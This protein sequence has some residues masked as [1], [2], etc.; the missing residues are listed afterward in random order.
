MDTLRSLFG[1]CDMFTTYSH[2]VVATA[3]EA[4]CY[5]CTAVGVVLSYLLALRG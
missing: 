5:F 3:V 2:E 1:A 4:V